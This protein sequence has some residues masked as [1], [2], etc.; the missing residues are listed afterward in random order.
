MLADC[1]GGAAGAVP[2]TDSKFVGK[3]VVVRLTGDETGEEVAV[4][5]V[6]GVASGP[7]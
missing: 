2:E 1:P 7:V 4:E 5:A 6:G 3:E